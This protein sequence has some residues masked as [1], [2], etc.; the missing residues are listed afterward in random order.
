MAQINNINNQQEPSSKSPFEM[1]NKLKNQWGV[2]RPIEARAM[3]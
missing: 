3:T 1:K 2:W